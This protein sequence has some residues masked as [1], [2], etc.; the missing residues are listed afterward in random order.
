MKTSIPEEAPLPELKDEEDEQ[1]DF[2]LGAD[3]DSR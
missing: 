3:E 2:A 1:L